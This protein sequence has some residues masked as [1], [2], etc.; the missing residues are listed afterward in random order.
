VRV[1]LKGLSK[2]TAVLAT[3]ERKTYWYAW[4]GGPRLHG[5]PGTPEFMRSYNEAVAQ[6]KMPP[7]GL[8]LSLIAEF[9]RSA[10]FTTTSPASQKNYL[11]YLR[12]GG[13]VRRSADRRP[14]R[15]AHAG[16]VQGVA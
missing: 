12:L 16:T 10:E 11:R 15:P 8:M 7:K 1:Q 4:R 14:R 9:K 2:A 3:G 5:E 6:R 13:S